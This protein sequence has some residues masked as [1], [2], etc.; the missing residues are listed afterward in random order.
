[1]FINAICLRL[2]YGN[3]VI[4]RSNG[5]PVPLMGPPPLTR[6]RALRAA[7]VS[8]ESNMARFIVKAAVLSWL[9]GALTIGAL[10]PSIAQYVIVS[11]GGPYG[12]YGG[13]AYPPGIYFPRYRYPAG[14]DTGGMPYSYGDLGWHW[15]PRTGAPANPCYP[16]LRS[17]NRC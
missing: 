4:V 15:G 9:I 16:G 14:Y 7:V 5:G 12:Y 3:F 1:M 11:P 17:F 6:Y 13:L 10:A 8:V 2:T